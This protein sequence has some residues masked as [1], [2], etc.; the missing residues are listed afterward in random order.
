MM[1]ECPGVRSAAGRTGTTS[2]AVVH[3]GL[4]NEI[5]E[6]GELDEVGSA[7]VFEEI[8]EFSPCIRKPECPN[9]FAWPCPVAAKIAIADATKMGMKMKR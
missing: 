5:T 3:V 2:K 4:L 6:V 7:T 1:V 9:T 8:A